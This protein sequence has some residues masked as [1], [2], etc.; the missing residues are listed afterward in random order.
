MSHGLASS[1]I[2]GEI[3][4]GTKEEEE[5][6]VGETKVTEAMMVGVMGETMAGVE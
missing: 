2:K 5:A 3:K 1:K 6:M 4:D